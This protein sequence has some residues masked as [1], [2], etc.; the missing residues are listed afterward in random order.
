MIDARRG[1]VFGGIYDTELKCIKSDRLISLNELT[2]DI[3]NDYEFVSYDDVP[4]TLLS[5]PKIDII[6]IVD[7]HK[8]DRGVNPHNLNPNYL[9]LTEA[10]ENKLKDD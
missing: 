2:K 8:N 5:R 7:K 10:E 3:N 1:N 9:K 6:K 4:V